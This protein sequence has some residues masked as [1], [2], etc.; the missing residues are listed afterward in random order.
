[1][2]AAPPERAYGPPV[3]PTGSR[4]LAFTAPCPRGH[5]DAGWVSVLRHVVGQASDDY[6]DDEL[7][8]YRLR[9]ADCDA[10]EAHAPAP[11]PG[12]GAADVVRGP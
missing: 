1:M 8:S 3:D 4:E 6:L 11:A 2:L 9:C 5:P 7:P 12:R 10:A